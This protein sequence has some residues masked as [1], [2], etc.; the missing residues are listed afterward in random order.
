MSACECLCVSERGA[1]R[2]GFDLTVSG[3]PKTTTNFSEYLLVYEG[4]KY[5]GYCS[6][7]RMR[8]GDLSLLKSSHLYTYEYSVA[9]T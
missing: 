6:Y 7:C 2:A 5:P 4:S 3:Q 9:V 8:V 1:E